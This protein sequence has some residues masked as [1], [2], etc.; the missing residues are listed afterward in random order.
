MKV[1]LITAICDDEYGNREVVGCFSSY[2]LAE[3]EIEKRGQEFVDFWDGSI[4]PYFTIEEWE[5]TEN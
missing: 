5:V 2:E 4:E 3:K 1:Y